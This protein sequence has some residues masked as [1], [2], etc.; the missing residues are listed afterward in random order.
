MTIMLRG[1]YIGD[2]PLLREHKAL[3]MTEK[4]GYTFDPSKIVLA[5]F[6]TVTGPNGTILTIGDLDRYE[7]LTGVNRY[8]VG[9]H[10]FALHDFK[11]EEIGG[12]VEGY[13]RVSE[14]VWNLVAKALKSMK[15][16]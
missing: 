9:W 12:R 7:T 14:P 13:N 5:Q 1:E 16:E 15:Y 6:D 4:K 8:M 2:D 11:I 10:A 3:L